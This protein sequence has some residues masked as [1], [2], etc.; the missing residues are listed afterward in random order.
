MTLCFFA[1]C[2]VSKLEMCYINTLSSQ[3]NAKVRGKTA[4][5][6]ASAEGY[7]SVLKTLLEFRPQLNVEVGGIL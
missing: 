4:L 2:R 3:V 7:T 1:V 5:H 6:L